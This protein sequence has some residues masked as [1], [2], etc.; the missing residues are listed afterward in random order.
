MSRTRL[1][2]GICLPLL[3][4][5]APTVVAIQSYR[6]HAALDPRALA[7]L[8]ALAESGDLDKARVLT[9]LGPPI[10]VI[11]QAARSSSTATWPG[12]PA[13]ST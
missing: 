12:T 11:G 5:C 2:L 8:S 1:A 9:V 6:A 10:G 3:A 13:S 7:T 4:A